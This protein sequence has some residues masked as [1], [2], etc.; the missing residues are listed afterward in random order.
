MPVTLQLRQLDVP[1]GQRSRIH[2]LGWSEFEQILS[3]LGE[4]RSTRIAYSKNVLEIRMPL[5]Q[6]ERAKS[7]LGDIVK[8]IL[9]EL[10][11]DCECFGSTTF[12]NQKMG[13]GLEPNDCFYIQ[14]HQLMIGKD[15]IDL[16]VDPPPDLAIE[17]D[18]TSKTQMGAYLSLGVPELWICEQEE[19][20]I[21]V[22]QSHQYHRVTASPSLPNVPI[23]ELA[24][25]VLARSKIVGRSPALRELRKQV[26]QFL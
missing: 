4:D 7:I 12:K 15:R 8:I 20:R 16:A 26:R 19:L 5:P 25:T 13:Y 3:E 24:V 18:V 10:E 22:L 9:E 14:N 1:P 2:D 11:L 21:Y 17:V 6:H 23:L